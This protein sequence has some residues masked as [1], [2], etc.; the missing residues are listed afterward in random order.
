M[1]GK[2]LTFGGACLL[3]FILIGCGGGESD[4]SFAPPAV[5]SPVP[6]YGARTLLG[7][8]LRLADLQGKVVL[9]NVWATWCGPC[10]REMTKLQALHDTYGAQGLAVLG[11]S[12]DRGAAEG[13]VRSFIDQHGISFGILLDPDGV[14]ESRFRTLGVPE[15]FLIDREGVLRHRWI[16]EFDPGHREVRLEIESLLAEV[17]A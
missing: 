17:G 13:E 10:V 2:K 4:R 8:E 9:L 6:S 1:R 15:S 7:E 14:V 16:G 12:V 5:G 3:L 11:V